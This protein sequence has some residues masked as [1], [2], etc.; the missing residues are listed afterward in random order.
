M[1]DKAEGPL[2]WFGGEMGEGTFRR[3]M[4]DQRWVIY[5]FEIHKSYG[6]H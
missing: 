5:Q 2:S 4:V 1:Q 3:Q 6:M